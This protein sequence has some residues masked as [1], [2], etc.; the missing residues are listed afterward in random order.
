M[1]ED[2]TKSAS[3]NIAKETEDGTLSSAE[4]RE[5]EKQK[6]EQDAH[7]Q[8]LHHTQISLS[9]CKKISYVSQFLVVAIAVTAFCSIAYLSIRNLTSSHI[10]QSKKIIPRNDAWFKLAICVRPFIQKEI[11]SELYRLKIGMTLDDYVKSLRPPSAWNSTQWLDVTLRPLGYKLYF[12][13]VHPWNKINVSDVW[14]YQNDSFRKAFHEFKV[15][16]V[17]ITSKMGDM[18]TLEDYDNWHYSG[19]SDDIEYAVLTTEKSLNSTRADYA[20]LGEYSLGPLYGGCL[21]ITVNE[22][23]S[24]RQMQLDVRFNSDVYS[25][26]KSQT[27]NYG[28][29]RV[30]T[31]LFGEADLFVYDTGD[32]FT[33]IPIIQ[34]FSKFSIRSNTLERLWVTGSSHQREATKAKHCV[35]TTDYSQTN[36]RKWC[37]M[38]KLLKSLECILPWMRDVIQKPW[39][40][41]DYGKLPVCPDQESF[42][43][44]WEIQQLYLTSTGAKMPRPVQKC[45]ESCPDHCLS[46]KVSLLSLGSK[47]VGSNYGIS[48][49][50]SPEVESV[51]EHREYTFENMVA[52]LSASISFLLG[53]SAIAIYDWLV[54]FGVWSAIRLGLYEDDLD[55]EDEYYAP[56][57]EEAAWPS[58]TVGGLSQLQVLP[59]ERG[60][61]GSLTPSEDGRDDA[62]SLI[63]YVEPSA[64]EAADK[65]TSPKAVAAPRSRRRDSLELP[66]VGSGPE[67]GSWRPP[68][69]SGDGLSQYATPSGGS[70]QPNPEA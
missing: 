64:K 3:K 26:Y 4:A 2:L 8:G 27:S 47:S 25:K 23:M 65:S 22:T 37:I 32:F 67:A 70:S 69:P 7:G 11:L 62:A 10:L 29:Q 34:K 9:A 59:E 41:K 43:K 14:S 54:A 13:E 55:G 39:M 12:Q 30:K 51:R 17:R 19:T 57:G 35:N 18:D 44:T 46:F 31:N 49:T 56:D 33:E 36:C 68:T 60:E 16:D 52:E 45:M 66:T 1:S 50:I 28:Q 42:T 38:R 15:N 58:D 6:D 48:L 5:P 20:L 40:E 61:G 53:L 21:N 63:W 24:K